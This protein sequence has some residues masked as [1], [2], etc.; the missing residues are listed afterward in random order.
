MKKNNIINLEKFN[1]NFEN[2]NQTIKLL[3]LKTST[4]NIEVAIYEK[5]KFIKK[6]TIAFAHLPKKIKAKINPLK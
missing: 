1:L 4:M 2:N 5:N 3:I 6:S